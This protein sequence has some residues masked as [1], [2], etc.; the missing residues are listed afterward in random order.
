MS[1]TYRVVLMIWPA[2]PMSPRVAVRLRGLGVDLDA[3]RRSPAA[4]TAWHTDKGELGLTLELTRIDGPVG[5]KLLLGALRRDGVS[6]YAWGYYDSERVA[7]G[8]S[9]TRERALDLTFAVLPSGEHLLRAGEV[10]SLASEHETL[11]AFRGALEARIAQGRP[12]IA[13]F[14][15]LG[16]VRITV[17][18]P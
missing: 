2:T 10:E 4:I 9:H 7:L 6:Y 15:P 13:S 16:Q 5:L 1:A 17:E 14:Q 11:D 18:A 3:L 12:P 8:H